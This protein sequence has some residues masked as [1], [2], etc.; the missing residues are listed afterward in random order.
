MYLTRTGNN[1]PRRFDLKMLHV[2]CDWAVTPAG[3]IIERLS[4]PGRIDSVLPL[5][6]RQQ[7]R[8]AVFQPSQDE[9]L[10]APVPTGR[11]SRRP[12]PDPHDADRRRPFSGNYY[13]VEGRA[14]ATV[15]WLCGVS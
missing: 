3:A 15:F 4:E 8:T 7:L 11:Q 1:D 6:D 10:A 12:R 14:L 5:S 2:T 9:N 13:V